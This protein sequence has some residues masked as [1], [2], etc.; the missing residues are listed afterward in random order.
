MKRY[1]L[2]SLALL[3]VIWCLTLV[4]I[5]AACR[6]AWRLLEFGWGLA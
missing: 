2:T 6:L 1:E 3:A 5:G 4:A